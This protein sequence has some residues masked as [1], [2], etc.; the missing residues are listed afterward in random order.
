MTSSPERRPRARVFMAS[1]ELQFIFAFFDDGVASLA[2]QYDGA[3]V[4]GNDNLASANSPNYSTDESECQSLSG[5]MM[6]TM[7][8]DPQF[9]FLASSSTTCDCA[10]E[11]LLLVPL[12]HFQTLDLF[13]P[14]PCKTLLPL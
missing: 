12:T 13:D 1:P 9:S 7:M 6:M 11:C 4:A 14:L 8:R 5:C 2:M 3:A 10:S